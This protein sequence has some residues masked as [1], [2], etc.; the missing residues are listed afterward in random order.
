MKHEIAASENRGGSIRKTVFLSGKK[1]KNYLPF[2]LMFLP[3][4]IYYLLFHYFPMSGVVIAFKNYNFRQGIL[5]S[6][7][8]SEYGLHHFLRFINNGDFWRIFGNTLILASMRIFLTFPIPIILALMLNNV[9]SP[10]YKSFL[11]TISYL[12]HFVSFVIVYSFVYNF[13]SSQGVI[14]QLRQLLGLN[15]T[16]YLA[17]AKYYRWIFV[18]TALWKGMGWNAIIYLAALTGINVELYEAAEL[19]GAGRWRKLWHI[20]LSEIRPIISIQFVLSMGGILSV[21]FE[22]TLVM[23]NS[24][25]LSVAEDIGYYIYKV[26]ILSNNQFSYATAIGFFN[27]TLA[28]MIVLITNKVAKQIDEDGGLW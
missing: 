13:F 23:I 16:M 18:G 28:L 19:D 14:N 24:T 22:Q 9:K 15:A 20:T 6:A 11:Q 2:Y 5:G 8:T 3:V 1:W 21:N 17:E 10:L 7:W 4:F 27:S 26:G 12:P 25:V